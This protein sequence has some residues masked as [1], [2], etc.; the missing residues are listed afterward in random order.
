MTHTHTHTPHW[1]ANEQLRAREFELK[2]ECD[3]RSQIALPRMKAVDNNRRAED[4][5]ALEDPTPGV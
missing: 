4:S 5:Q 3:E 2:Y 1:Q